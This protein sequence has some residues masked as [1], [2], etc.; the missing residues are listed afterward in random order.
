[1]FGSE[2][3]ETILPLD[4]KQVLLAGGGKPLLFSAWRFSFWEYFWK[5]FQAFPEFQRGLA[6]LET[7]VEALGIEGRDIEN[8]LTGTWT[9]LAG[10]KAAIGDQEI[11]GVYLA[12]TGKD[13]AALKLTQTVL[14]SEEIGAFLPLV[15]RR[16]PGWQLAYKVSE[17]IL[18]IPIPIF[19]GVKDETFFIGVAQSEQMDK[20]PEGDSTFNKLLEAENQFGY[21]YVG[22]QQIW[23]EI[24]RYLAMPYA[25]VLMDQSLRRMRMIDLKDIERF[26]EAV[27]SI[28]SISIVQ[29][30]ANTGDILIE[31]Q[32]VEPKDRIITHAAQL[33]ARLET[34]R[35]FEALIDGSDVISQLADLREIA[36]EMLA[37]NPEF[38]M[39][40]GKNYVAELTGDTEDEEY[41]SFIKDDNGRCYAGVLIENFDED[42]EF[43]ADYVE[44]VAEKMGFWGSSS[45][46][47]A[48]ETYFKAQDTILWLPVNFD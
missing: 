6:E 3:L 11:P 28:K 37:G 26:M 34:H 46:T 12:I 36:E 41:G 16:V 30:E 2:I 43:D 45:L 22:T 15:P 24:R 4:P 29:P 21:S 39:A 31:T 38:E 14:E 35:Q 40:P 5:E 10:N 9:L 44:T 7:A 27:P 13:G 8:L 1:M 48:P 18:P 23:D 33:F 20:I 17:A 47:K 19:L 32:D 42:E 25:R